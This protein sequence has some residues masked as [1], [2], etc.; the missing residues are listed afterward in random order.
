VDSLLT[1][2]MH[3]TT[4][5]ELNEYSSSKKLQQSMV[6]DENFQKLHNYIVYRSFP[7]H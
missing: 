5:T 4:E 7:H 6:K 1:Q 2:R 3:L